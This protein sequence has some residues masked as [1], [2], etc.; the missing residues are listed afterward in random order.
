MTKFKV[1]D[2]VV[3]VNG[4]WG[5][6][7]AGVIK[8]GQ[9]CTV[10]SVCGSSVYI[11]VDNITVGV[12]IH[13]FCAHYFELYVEPEVDPFK[14]GDTVICINNKGQEGRLQEGCGYLVKSV[15]AGGAIF[16]E[17]INYPLMPSRFK[18]FEDRKFTPLKRWPKEPEIPVPNLSAPSAHNFDYLTVGESGIVLHAEIYGHREDDPEPINLLGALREI[19]ENLPIQFKELMDALADE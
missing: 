17:H 3:R 10:T 4:D 5:G 18:K 2:K 16:L 6:G 8:A 19:K 14:V 11:Q 13:P 1:G 7:E 9:I 15:S 12:D